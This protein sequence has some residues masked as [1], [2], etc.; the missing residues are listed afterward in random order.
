MRKRNEAYLKKIFK[1]I[2]ITGMEQETL[3]WLT[4]WEP[5]ALKNI[6]SAFKKIR[7]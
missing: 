1:G 2:K 7:G 6:V 4:N 3:S 5:E